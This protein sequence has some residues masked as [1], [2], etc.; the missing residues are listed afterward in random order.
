MARLPYLDKDD[1]TDEDKE[2]VKRPINLN[3]VIAHSP[4]AARK[5]SGIGNY[6]RFGS[7]LDPRL[8]EMAILQ[9]GY[10]TK[11]AYEYS[12]H[13]KIGRDFGVADDDVVAIET[14]TAGGDSG[15]PALDRAVLRGTREMT[16]QTKVSNDTYAV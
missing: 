14:E 2:I 4:E 15:L 13:L 1:L 16:K 6:I 10:L 9:V 11:N 12:H 7:S 3:R 8:R 5:F